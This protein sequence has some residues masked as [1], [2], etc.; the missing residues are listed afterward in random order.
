MKGS[1]CKDV[2]VPFVDEILIGFFLDLILRGLE[3]SF[4]CGNCD[5]DEA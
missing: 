2:F 4:V 3:D 5:T 1:T